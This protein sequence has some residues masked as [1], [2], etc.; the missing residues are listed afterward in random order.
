MPAMSTTFL[1]HVA[2][3]GPRRLCRPCESAEERRRAQEQN[4]GRAKTSSE[5]EKRDQGTRQRGPEDATGLFGAMGH[6]VRRT[7]TVVIHQGWN[8]RHRCG[9]VERIERAQACR[10]DVNVPKLD[11]TC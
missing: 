8:D 10:D 5:T 6:G 9:V 3:L 4:S 11:R 2:G 7:K 1:R